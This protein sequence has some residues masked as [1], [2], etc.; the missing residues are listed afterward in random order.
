MNC[1]FATHAAGDGEVHDDRGVGLAFLA[2]GDVG[3]DA[4]LAVGHGVHLVAEEFQRRLRQLADEI[5]VVHHE[6]AAVA[7]HVRDRLR[8]RR[9]HLF[10]GGGQMDVELSADT[11]RRVGGDDAVVLLDDGIGCGEAEAGAFVLRGEIGVED[12]A[13]VL[14]FDAGAVVLDGDAAVAPGDQP[15]RR[16]RLDRDVVGGDAHDAAAGHGLHGIDDEVL[17][18]LAELALIHLDGPQIRRRLELAA[19]VGAAQRE[20]R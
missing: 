7:L 14:G 15:Q 12:F 3:L 16:V 19:H 1:L 4:R 11:P 10:L 17:D 13:E 2:C 18:D 5:L 9:L 6:D 20:A 8:L